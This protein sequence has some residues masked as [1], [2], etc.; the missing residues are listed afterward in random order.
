MYVTTER[1]TPASFLPLICLVLHHHVLP[2]QF[3]KQLSPDTIGVVIGE[4]SAIRQRFASSFSEPDQV[5]GSPCYLVWCAVFHIFLLFAVGPLPSL[6]SMACSQCQMP[7]FV[8]Q[9]LLR[10]LFFGCPCHPFSMPAFLWNGFSNSISHCTPLHFFALLL[11]QQPC[12]TTPRPSSS[13]VQPSQMPSVPTT[14][15]TDIS[16]SSSAALL[17][18]RFP[19]ASSST[20]SLDNSIIHKSPNAPYPAPQQQQPTANIVSSDAASLSSQL[21]GHGHS[22]RLSG[23]AIPSATSSVHGTSLISPASTSCLPSH[24]PNPLSLSSNIPNP[25]I[26]NP[27]SAS[28][29]INVN[30]TPL[31][32]PMTPLLTSTSSTISNVSSTP[33][34]VPI[35][36]ASQISGTTSPMASDVPCASGVPCEQPIPMSFAESMVQNFA[37]KSGKLK[38][39]IRRKSS[40]PALE[41]VS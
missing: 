12:L 14:Q 27:S 8:F 32:T 1:L 28:R 39:S 26:I 17:P 24:P 11:A 9:S 40:T 21:R 13:P 31:I 18:P 3:H 33:I 25:I 16:C 5:S 10:Q 35:P 41:P 15:P 38:I 30:S 29:N 4:L 19:S 36:S 6:F 37:K 2:F 7:A 23:S 20:Q 22:R 34:L